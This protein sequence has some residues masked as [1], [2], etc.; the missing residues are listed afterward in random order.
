MTAHNLTASSSSASTVR[1]LAPKR[2]PSAVSTQGIEDRGV[3]A[4]LKD[5]LPLSKHAL[6]HVRLTIH[7]LWN[8]PLVSG[9]FS[10]KWKFQNVHSVRGSGMTMRE[11]LKAKM[12]K[13]KGKEGDGGEEERVESNAGPLTSV[14]R[15]DPD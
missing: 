11:G 7:Q 14:V 6:F 1:P 9:A 15:F 4:H 12:R 2:T 10:V 3:R 13:G 8:V 5:L